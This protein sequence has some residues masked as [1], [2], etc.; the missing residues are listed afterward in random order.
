MTDRAI[1][2]AVA[3]AAIR[4]HVLARS[5]GG[6]GQLGEVKHL[7]PVL[8]ET[9]A[10]HVA[11][12][13]VEKNRKTAIPNWSPVGNVD[14]LARSGNRLALAAELKWG[15]HDKIYEGIW[16]LFKMALLAKDS[17]RPS[18]YLVMGAPT[19]AWLTAV[20]HAV[21]SDGIHTPQGLC[22]LTF[23]KRPAWDYL[24]E[25]GHEKCPACVPAQI[26]TSLVARERL[27]GAGPEW[28]LRAV[29]VRPVGSDVVPFHGGWPFGNRPP[30]AKYPL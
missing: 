17:G 15:N 29:R 4:L 14:L 27:T 5:S 3:D 20:G 10:P 26:E 24:L 23:P 9:L 8:V 1:A 11:P 30:D 13:T 22:A 2:S 25:G 28:E 16:D 12:A 7:E 19:T 6:F 21:F 18:T